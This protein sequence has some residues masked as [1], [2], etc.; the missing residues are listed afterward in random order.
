MARWRNRP[1]PPGV[2]WWDLEP[3]RRMTRR[4]GALV[5]PGSGGGEALSTCGWRWGLRCASILTKGW[6][7][8]A[9][10]RSKEA[11]REFDDI[12]ARS[13]ERRQ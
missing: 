3:A 4:C 13:A 11:P 5:R 12:R 10:W 7:P 1:P 9:R 6:R 2:A 8:V